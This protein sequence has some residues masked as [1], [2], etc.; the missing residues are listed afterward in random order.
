MRHKKIIL[1]LVLSLAFVFTSVEVFAFDMPSPT[2]EQTTIEAPRINFVPAITIPGFSVTNVDGSTLANYIVSV[3]RYGGMFASIVAMF[4][5]VYAGWEWL[6]AGGNSSKISQAKNKINSTLVGLVVLFGGYLLLSLI[7]TKLVSFN[8]LNTNLPTRAEVC[9]VYKEKKDCPAIC[10]WVEATP[11]AIALNASAKGSCVP[12]I[13]PAESSI[14][15]SKF[16]VNR[17]TYPCSNY[18]DDIAACNDNVCHNQSTIGGVIF[19][20]IC[21]FYSN[22]GCVTLDNQDCTDDSDCQV[23]NPSGIEYYCKQTLLLW[24]T[25]VRR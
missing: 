5:L 4:M 10:S 22:G 16:L 8:S 12:Y 9:A 7:S 20:E 2:S 13:M 19:E 17:A 21:K 15:C 18:G 6:L 23:N 11:E 14:D 24:R 25:C 3:Y 1:L